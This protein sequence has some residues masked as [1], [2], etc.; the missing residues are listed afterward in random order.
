MVPVAVE[1][2]LEVVG[3][4]VESGDGHDCAE[5]A[6]RCRKRLIPLRPILRE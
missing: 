3:V 1:A 2:M 6:A 4:V 5:V